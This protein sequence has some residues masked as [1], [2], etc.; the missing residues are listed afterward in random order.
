MNLKCLIHGRHPWI[1]LFIRIY[2]TVVL[3]VT[4]CLFLSLFFLLFCSIYESMR[5]VNIDSSPNDVCHLNLILQTN[6]N[7]YWHGSPTDQFPELLMS[8]PLHDRSWSLC[9]FPVTSTLFLFCLSRLP[10]SR[11]PISGVLI[12]NWW[13]LSQGYRR[14]EWAEVGRKTPLLA[15]QECS[16]CGFLLALLLS[17]AWCVIISFPATW[18]EE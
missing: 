7:K 18:N 12:P 16:P 11:G 3:K 6:I 5:K 4:Q 15:W 8:S 14:M 13:L 1:L 17:G 2:W 10:T 9:P